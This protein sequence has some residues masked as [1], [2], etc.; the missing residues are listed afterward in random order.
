MWEYE[1]LF[2]DFD[3]LGIFLLL[4]RVLSN[5]QPA[6]IGGAGRLFPFI[7]VTS[8]AIVLNGLNHIKLHKHML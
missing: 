4:C 3:S 7:I 6:F 1:Y 5:F 2:V 8:V